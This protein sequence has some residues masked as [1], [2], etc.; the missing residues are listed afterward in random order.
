MQKEYE[1]GKELAPPSLPSFLFQYYNTRELLGSTHYDSG[2]TIVSAYKA[3][4]KHG[5][6]GAEDW[7]YD[8]DKYTIKPPQQAYDNASKHLLLEYF[9]V[10]SSLNNLKRCIAAGYGFSF[11]FQVK[12]S[13]EDPDGVT[14]D[15]IMR[16]GG[17]FD[18]T[19]GG[20]A[21]FAM[22]YDDNFKTHQRHDGAFKIRNSWSTSW[23][24]LGG[25]F[26]MPYSIIE[27]D[28]CDEFFS[29]RRAN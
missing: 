20:H 28:L 15:G 16:K 27:S 29:P 12:E 3:M 7:P 25:S 8:V 10:G 18:R 2:G 19:L 26:W 6:C 23:G 13:F 24:P 4:S 1:E 17:F 11:G 21:V 22:A 9:D 5:I 14:K